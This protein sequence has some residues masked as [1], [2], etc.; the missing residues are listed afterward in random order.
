MKY[1]LGIDVGTTG[2]KTLLFSENGELLGHAYQ[3]YDLITPQVG[4]SEQKATDWWDAIVKTVNE[5]VAAAGTDVGK[6][7]AGISL[8][9]QGGTFVPVDKDFKPLTNARVWNDHRCEKEHEEF[10][11]EVGEA[12]LMY[13]KTGW[14]LGKGLLALEIRWMKNNE[15]DLYNRTHMFLSVPSYVS[16]QMTG[17]PA[18]DFSDAGIDQ[19]GNVREEKYDADLLKFMGIDETRL[20]KLVHTGDVIGHL[21]EEAAKELS[22]TT[23]CVLVAGAH[24]QYAVALGS[25]AVDS[26]DI[27]IGS[28]TCWVVTALAD[29]ANFESGIAQSKSAV[30]G[31]WGSCWSLSSGGV[32]LDWFRKSVAL[33]DPEIRISYDE[34][35]TIVPDRKAAED[36]LFFYPFSGYA[37]GRRSFGKAAFLGLDLSHDRYDMMRAIMEGVA[38][39]IKG[40]MSYFKAQPDPEDGLRLAGGATK[41]ALWCQIVA[42]ITGY[43]VRVPEVADLACV[44]AAV[45]AGTGSGIFKDLS[46]GCK[47]LAVKEHV[48][49][50]DPE[51][52]ELFAKLYEEYMEK[53]EKLAEIY[54]M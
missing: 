24:D 27:L 13:Q 25:G 26:G 17:I 28:G 14:S 30:P 6:N 49:M 35:N 46:E 10:L 33:V 54:G 9:L 42:D 47:A 31:L 45:L 50:P 7:V 22:L 38:F 43:P 36:G 37:S 1:V 41:S 3:G 12:G 29:E 15:N 18:C 53:G 11:K 48:L 51:R 34:L 52:K 21:T 8:S 19:T 4:W 39:Q 20:P 40:M 44:G 23:D 5:V 2:T 16:Y 32:C